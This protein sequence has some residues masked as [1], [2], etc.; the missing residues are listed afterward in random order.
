MANPHELM[1][2]WV[3]QQVRMKRVATIDGCA[4][5]VKEFGNGHPF[6]R[7]FI[8]RLKCIEKFK[9]PAK[10]N[11]ME[12]QAKP[13]TVDPVHELMVSVGKTY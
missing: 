13:V 5:A 9:N 3:S 6:S 12:K 4:L 7:C 8:M 11:H 1:G 2:I 10:K